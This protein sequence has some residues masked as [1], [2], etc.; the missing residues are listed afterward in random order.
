LLQKGKRKAK[1]KM[2]RSVSWGVLSVQKSCEDIGGNKG[3]AR[4]REIAKEGRNQT[5]HS[6]RRDRVGT[7][8]FRAGQG[9]KTAV[10]KGR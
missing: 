5:E 2:F 3:N 8:V 7:G 1:Q 9:K 10:G 6:V 4:D